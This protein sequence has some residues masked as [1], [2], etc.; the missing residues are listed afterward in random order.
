M[1]NTELKNQIF[2]LTKYTENYKVVI[3]ID[4]EWDEEE[5]HHVQ[6]NVWHDGDFTDYFL[7]EYKTIE[8]AK[9][10]VKSVSNYLKKHFQHVEYS[11][12]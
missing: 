5:N 1:T 12:D 3:D 7:E 2:K 8:E 4:S 11:L 10:K 6:V 9:K